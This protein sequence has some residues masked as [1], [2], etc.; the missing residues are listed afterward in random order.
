MALDCCESGTKSPRLT[1]SRNFRMRLSP[2]WLNFYPHV[3]ELRTVAHSQVTYNLKGATPGLEEAFPGAPVPMA[4]GASAGEKARWLEVPLCTGKASPAHWDS[5]VGAKPEDE[6][7]GQ[8]N[9]PLSLSQA[10]LE[11]LSQPQFLKGCD[12]FSFHYPIF[13]SHLCEGSACLL[14]SGLVISLIGYILKSPN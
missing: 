2:L 10:P 11:H 13:L 14:F 5:T 12:M 1:A 9:G 4:E 6:F 8:N 3:S 7:A